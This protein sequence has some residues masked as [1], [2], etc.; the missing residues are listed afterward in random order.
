[1]LNGFIEGLFVAWFL[2]I[3]DVDEI[4]LEVMSSICTSIDF[5]KSHYY[6]LFGIF[7][8]IG[9]LTKAVL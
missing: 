4:I 8:A 7:G 1:M 9:G 6:V 3:F 5:T 2:S